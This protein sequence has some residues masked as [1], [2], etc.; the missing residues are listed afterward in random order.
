MQ[1]WRILKGGPNITDFSIVTG[2]KNDRLGIAGYIRADL[3]RS[4][5]RLGGGKVRNINPPIFYRLIPI[6]PVMVGFP[7]LSEEK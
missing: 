5:N 6:T 1:F 3:Y 4:T 2:A 7:L